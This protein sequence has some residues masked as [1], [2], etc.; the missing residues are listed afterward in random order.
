MTL[1]IAKLADLAKQMKQLRANDGPI[2]CHPDNMKLLEQFTETPEDKPLGITL[3]MF[4]TPIIPTRSV[5]KTQKTGRL[6]WPKD[7]F[8]SYEESDRQWGLALGIAKEEEETVF[9]RV[10]QLTPFVFANYA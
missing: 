10:P 8:V 7:P 2:Y 5:P 4:E 1:D 6:V 9:F 3:R